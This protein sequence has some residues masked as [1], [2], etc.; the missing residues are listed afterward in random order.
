MPITPIKTYGSETWKGRIPSRPEEIQ[1]F[2]Q[3]V[4]SINELEETSNSPKQDIAII[5]YACDIG[6]KR[7]QGRIGA[8]E[9]PAVMRRSLA[10]L[11]WHYGDRKIWDYGDVV[12][13]DNNLEECQ[14]Q[15]AAQITSALDNNHLPIG[16][17][18]GHDI[19][20][21]HYLGLKKHLQ[22]RGKTLGI[23]NFDAHFDLRKPN[24]DG[25][26]GT[27]FY[28]SLTDESW[29][30]RYL[31][32]GLQQAGNIQALYRTAERLGVDYITLEDTHQEAKSLDTINRFIDQV[33][34]LYLTIDLDGF[35]YTLA[36]GVSAPS[37]E[38]LDYNWTLSIL[39][40]LIASG[41]VISCDLAEFNPTYDIDNHTAK[42]G[43]RLIGKIISSL[44]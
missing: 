14:E 17:G 1:Y 22:P 5:G 13:I 42:L 35:S 36:P 2:Y 16:I 6:V 43:A 28:Q 39:D 24:P 25:T 40:Y 27:P 31:P 10:S 33:D 12:G 20:Y 44:S 32:I 37:P 19:A 29:S 8:A 30:V 7:N 38:G 21:A 9:G 23:I 11:A 41:K 3:S 15:F 18:G 4:A 26:S 34:C